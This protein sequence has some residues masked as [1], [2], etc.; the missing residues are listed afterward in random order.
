MR[1]KTMMDLAKRLF[2]PHWEWQLQASVRYEN[3]DSSPE[4][5]GWLS[6]ICEKKKK[7]N[8]RAKGKKKTWMKEKLGGRSSGRQIRKRANYVSL[9]VCIITPAFPRPFLCFLELVNYQGW[10]V[11]TQSTLH[12]LFQAI[13]KKSVFMFWRCWWG[14]DKISELSQI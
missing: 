9:Y 14:L 5:W 6:S 8:E 13:K 1:D 2:G 7:W 4:P 12:I 3:M 10:T 11:N